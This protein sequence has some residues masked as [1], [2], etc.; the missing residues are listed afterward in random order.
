MIHPAL[1]FSYAD[2]TGIFTGA[3]RTTSHRSAWARLGIVPEKRGTGL[4]TRVMQEAIAASRARGEK[5]MLLEV[6]EQNTPAVKLYR[7]LG[8]DTLRRLVGYRLTNPDGSEEDIEEMD[9][10]EFSRVEAS[11][12]EDGLTWMLA[13][14]TCS[15]Y[16]P[17]HQAYRLADRAFALVGDAETV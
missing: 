7:R 11:E 15:A 8:F 2:L 16:G 13:P 6:I 5:T 17:P 10:L 12:G 9:V 1:D 3:S 14:E 4:G